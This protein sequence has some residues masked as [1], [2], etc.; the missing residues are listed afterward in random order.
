MA[1]RRGTS[2]WAPTITILC[3]ELDARSPETSMPHARARA[4]DNPNDPGGALFVPKNLPEA[5]SG[6]GPV[7]FALIGTN[8]SGEYHVL[9]RDRKP[10]GAPERPR[11]LSAS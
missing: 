4:L 2:T 7:E 8:L 9:R 6:T 3:L 1:V 10:L 5:I 11:T